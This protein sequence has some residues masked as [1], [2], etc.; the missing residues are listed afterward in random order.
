MAEQPKDTIYID[1]DD[2]ITSIIDKV[3]GSSHRIVALVLPKRATVL[4]S[5]VNMRLLKRTGDT[6]KKH[7]V[8]IT[9][10][11]GILPLAGAVGV[12]VARTL[13]TKPA[14]PPSPS[15]PDSTPLT[16]SED[17]GPEEATGTSIDNTRP[18]GELASL[19]RQPEDETIEFDNDDLEPEEKLPKTTKPKK[20][21]KFKIPNFD[22]FRTKLILG[23]ILLVGLIVFWYFAF[24]VMPSARI[25]I[26]TYTT[27][28]AASLTM[29]ASSAAKE[30]DKQQK[31][32]PAITKEYKKTDA[33][34]AM[35][36]G[37]KDLG[38]KASGTVKFINCNKTD[39]LGDIV[40]T[41][42]AGTTISSGSKNFITT[43][44]VDVEP[45]SYTGDTCQAN[46]QS[47]SVVVIA[48]NGGDSYNL[49]ARDY[50]VSNFPTMT[51]KGSAMS[52]GTSNIVKVVSQADLDSAKQKILDQNLQTS[53]AEVSKLLVAEGYLALPDTLTVGA[54]V[55][56]SAPSVGDQATEVNV[57]VTVSYVMTGV[58]LDAVKQLIEEDSKGHIDTKKQ[59]ILDNG[60]DATVFRDVNKQANGDVRF[61]LQTEVVAGVQSD[62]TGI[63]KAIA[64][65]KKGEAQNIIGSRPGVKEVTINYSPFWVYKMPKQTGKITIT[66]EQVNNDNSSN[67][68]S[69]P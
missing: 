65:K 7:I 47:A 38:T 39:K 25:V 69:N 45:S 29:T 63:K 67:G 48:Q 44:A 54:P 14:I 13:Q 51:G 15:M 35:A 20:N 18:I 9:S 36:T 50:A 37:E 52:G 19:S 22:K 66:F 41:V 40:R 24:F 55:V 11:T 8:L 12:H 56:T 34:K 57:S 64:G 27:S 43:E 17:V 58:K 33:I 61:L 2:E 10:E 31:I 49:S 59:K 62:V 23:S 53:K 21:K 28:Y 32:V 26:K 60:L 4:Q 42:P 46:K 1:L 3:R 6:A 68:T 16:V 30:L 5:I